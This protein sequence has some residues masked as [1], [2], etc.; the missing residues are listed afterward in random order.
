MS[1]VVSSFPHLRAPVDTRRV[2]ATVIAALLPAIAAAAWIFGWRALVVIATCVVVAVAT[3]ALSQMAFGK[4]V[5]IAD[6]SAAVTGILLAFTLPAHVPL[7]MAAVG[8][9]V[10]IF[11]VKQL[12]GGLGFNIFNPAL[13]ARAVLL[14]SWPVAMTSWSLPVLSLASA[15]A[16]SSPSVL[17]VLKESARGGA[18]A[19][20]AVTYRDLLLG[21]VPGSL[22]ETCKVALLAGGAL[23]LVLRLIDWRVP[24][25]FIGSVA[26]LSWVFGRDPLLDVLSGG[27]ILGA[28]F[29]ATDMVTTPSTRK[30]KLIFGL[31]CGITT[32]L[33]RA[34]GGFPEGVCY[35][36]LFMNCVNLMIERFAVPRRFGSRRQTGEARGA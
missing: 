33:I 13:A 25:A 10:A 9:A 12:F 32:F 36:I 18:A 31:G 6:G 16:V 30:G 7:W 1:Y 20:L 17:G 22:G 34:W 28:F 3:E 4:K 19:D 27:L 24:V 23:L 15:D 35:S 26:L 29:M 11:L 2:M 21:T 5:T 8:A 14:S